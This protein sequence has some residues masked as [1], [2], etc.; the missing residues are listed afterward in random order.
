MTEP[1]EAQQARDDLAAQ[2]A[3]ETIRFVLG[4]ARALGVGKVDVLI[5][6]EIALAAYLTE[7]MQPWQDQK[8]VATFTNHLLARMEQMRIMEQP[9]EGNA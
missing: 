8:A 7:V 3:Q 6:C 1:S 2:L 4:R 5:A 9:A